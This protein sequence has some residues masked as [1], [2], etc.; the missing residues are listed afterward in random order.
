MHIGRGVA[1]LE[2]QRSYFIVMRDEV[3]KM[4]MAGKTVEQIQKEFQTPKEFAHYRGPRRQR[5]F[6]NLFYHQLLERG[7]WP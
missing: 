2:E 7:F 6:L 1:D 4:I 3:S 5:A